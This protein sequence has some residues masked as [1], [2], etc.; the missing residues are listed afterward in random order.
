MNS[1]LNDF[2][3]YINKYLN[4]FRG[5]KTSVHSLIGAITILLLIM[6]S[7]VFAPQ[8]P[9]KF[10]VLLNNPFIR[11][12]A[13]FLIAFLSHFSPTVSIV[14]A[15]TIIFTIDMVNR[16]YYDEHFNNIANYETFIQSKKEQYV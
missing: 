2:D 14:A 13:L 15:L 4:D 12:V 16:K 6:Y 3:I 1:T 11:V 7:G 9:S 8:I 5:E 10:A